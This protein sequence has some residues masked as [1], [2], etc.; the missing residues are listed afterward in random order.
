MG[1]NNRK[2]TLAGLAAIMLWSTNI[3][4]SKASMQEIGNYQAMFLIYFF[5]GLVMLGM[6][7][8]QMRGQFMKGLR[9]LGW[10]Y[11]LG[12]GIFLILNNTLFFAAIG[13]ATNESALLVVTILN[14]LWPVLIYVFRIPIFRIKI[15]PWRFFPGVVLGSAGVVLSFSQAHTLEEV[16]FLSGNLRDNYPAYIMAFL[17][18]ASWAVYSNLTGKSGKNNDFAALPFMFMFSGVVFMFILAQRKEI[19]TIPLE[20]LI[21]N[22]GLVYLI[23]FPTAV[24]YTLW[25]YAVKHGNRNLVVS[26]SFLLPFLSIIVI[27]IR[28]NAPIGP[29]TWF[30]V[31][32]LVAGSILCYRSEIKT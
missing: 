28:F 14:Y 4:F 16:R 5:S 20:A 23:L 7:A 10:E 11:Y 12:T 15:R 29:L 17:T 25:N 19:H 13:L 1:N 26:A 9:S 22:P 8:F 31:F 30:S 3:A 18:A 24:G 6:I 21:F 2:G 27:G 32:L